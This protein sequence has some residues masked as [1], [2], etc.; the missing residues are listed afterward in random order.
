[1]LVHAWF[2]ERVFGSIWKCKVFEGKIINH[3][4]YKN[5]SSWSDFRLPNYLSVCLSRLF[6]PVMKLIVRFAATLCVPFWK[7]GS[8]LAASRRV[9]RRL[10]TRKKVTCSKLTCNF[11][12]NT[13][14]YELAP[15]CM[16]HIHIYVCAYVVI[17][18]K[19]GGVA[20][21]AKNMRF[22]THLQ[23]LFK[24]KTTTTTNCK[25]AIQI[26]TL[27]YILWQF[28]FLLFSV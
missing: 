13:Y 14:Q 18:A 7:L 25:Y 6:C 16:L 1:M 23:Q 10:F 5:S 4:F 3:F 2:W 28:I 17:W 19:H 15:V 8:L 20:I 21:V 11:S 26:Y 27:F 9:R 12:E 24:T 22:A